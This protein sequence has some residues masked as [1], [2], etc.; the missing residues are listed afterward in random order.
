MLRRLSLPFLAFVSLALAGCAPKSE[1][2]PEE[3]V[4]FAGYRRFGVSPFL[5]PGGRGQAV[6]DAFAA[7][8]QQTLDDP[9]DQKAL[10]RILAQYKPDRDV[11]YRAEELETLRA[12]TG[13]DALIVGRMGPGWS[14]AAITV[15]ELDTGGPI[16]HALLR[17]RKGKAFASADDV[18]REFLRVYSKLR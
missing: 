15:I 11:G 17:P 3:A 14:S 4:N 8:L 10:A 13:A 12:Q 9:V 2:R 1:F 5:D 16:L 6:T 7:A 18:A